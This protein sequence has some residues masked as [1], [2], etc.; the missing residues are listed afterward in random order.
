[1][2]TIVLVVHT[3]CNQLLLEFSVYPFNVL[4]VLEMCMKMFNYVF[5]FFY[6]FTGFLI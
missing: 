3:L 5:F 2:F 4:Q 1:M 6:K